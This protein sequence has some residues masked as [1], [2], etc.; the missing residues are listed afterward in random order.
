M[1]L[2]KVLHKCLKYF[3]FVLFKVNE[4]YWSIFFYLPPAAK[5]LIVILA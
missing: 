3:Q 4:E 5:G 2:D 1:D